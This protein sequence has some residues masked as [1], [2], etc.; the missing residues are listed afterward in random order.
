MEYL[1]LLFLLVGCGNYKNG[2]LIHKE[3]S[4]ELN[5][6]RA[7]ELCSDI[8]GLVHINCGNTGWGVSSISCEVLCKYGK[9]NF[10]QIR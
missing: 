6:K 9:V 3:S 2:E 8:G 1:I 5:I 4:E 10:E 7:E